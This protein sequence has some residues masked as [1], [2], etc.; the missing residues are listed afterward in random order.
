MEQRVETIFPAIVGP[1]YLWLET[2]LELFPK[3]KARVADYGDERV[4]SLVIGDRLS[5]VGTKR[6]TVGWQEVRQLAFAFDEED[7]P[8]VQA[9]YAEHGPLGDPECLNMFSGIRE[10]VGWAAAATEW[11][12]TL[13]VLVEALQNDRTSQLWEQFGEPR[14][15]TISH[16]DEPIYLAGPHPFGDKPSFDYCIRWVPVRGEKGRCFTPQ[17]EAELYYATWQ[18]VIQAVEH[19]LARIHLTPIRRDYDDARHPQLHWGFAVEGALQEAFLDWFF[20]VFAP[21]KVRTCAASDCSNPVLAPRRTYC[22]PECRNRQ[23]Q[24]DHRERK[25]KQA[26]SRL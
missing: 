19:E 4:I 16:S 14:E 23:K 5:N 10:R 11:F 25:K 21:L 22:S 18:A 3:R 12:R 15:L 26:T 9:F 24:R 6:G 7:W 1:E 8:T 2:A 20:R 17:N 13:T